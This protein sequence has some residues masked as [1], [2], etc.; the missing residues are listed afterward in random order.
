LLLRNVHVIDGTGA[1]PT[2]PHD[3]LIEQGRIAR[4]GAP[5]SI[6]TGARGLDAT[7]HT[8][9]P[10]LM[11]LHAHVYRPAMLPSMV[12]FGVTTVRDQGSSMATLAAYADLIAAGLF[13]GP[14]LSYGGFQYYSDWGF[15]E[16]Q[17]RG[18]EPE[19]DPGHVARS[20]ALA[21]AF[22]AQHI[23]TRTFR[24]WD[25]NA[26]MIDAAHRLGLRAT[27]HC[28]HELPLILAGM[29]AKEHSGMCA[30]RVDGD[31]HDDLIQ[32]FRQADVAVVPTI[33]YTALAVRAK[34]HLDTLYADTSVAA[35]LPPRDDF[36]WMLHLDD[37]RRRA[38]ALESGRARAVTRKLH[39]AGVTI[40]L[41]TD[42][43]QT[44]T[45]VHME[46]EELVAAGL[47]PVEAIHAA[48][49]AAA[50]VIGAESDFGTIRPGMRADLVVLA[51]DPSIDIRNTRAIAYVIK[52]GAII[53]RAA[54][55]TGRA[56]AHS[57]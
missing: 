55:R 16:D 46:L 14:R 20:V 18:I 35:F 24:R 3:V 44:P 7:G 25:I 12:Y 32:L 39:R 48:T 13:P 31:M 22:G 6:A 5:G 37:G 41:G 51:A 43:W 28:A 45:A 23:K 10:G 38:L 21:A 19:A 26:R 1:A 2:G 11:D 30:T 27:G 54:I 8:L 57:P 53:D 56:M 42:V 49:G 47:T 40:G 9:I 50:K 17:G 34:E 33:S 29:D 4:I 52:D 15:D 36:G